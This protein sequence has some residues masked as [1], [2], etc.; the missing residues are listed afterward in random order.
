MCQ[1]TALE[2]TMQQDLSCIL[3]L[4]TMLIIFLCWFIHSCYY[5]HWTNSLKTQ[6]FPSWVSLYNLYEIALNSQT[7]LYIKWFINALWFHSCNT[8][9]LSWLSNQRVYTR[10]IVCYEYW[11]KY[12][13]NFCWCIYLD[14]MNKKGYI[15]YIGTILKKNMVF[16]NKAKQ[17]FKFYVSS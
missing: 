2:I 11:S 13:R 15:G 16:L 14:S 10:D 6:S 4:I 8:V 12:F 1:W 17:I 7:I 3:W 5:V 9:I